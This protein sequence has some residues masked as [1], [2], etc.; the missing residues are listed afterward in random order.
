MRFVTVRDLR[1]RPAKVW[2]ELSRR[3]EL[4]ITSNGKPI[5]IL[6]S[7]N[8]ETLEESLRAI[9]AARAMRA[10]D[11]IRRNAGRGGTHKLGMKAID[12]EIA[13]VRRSRRS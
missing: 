7:A 1:G 3:G 12:A 5:A 9:R 10:L 13:A 4:I 6:A 8:E 2:K 11:E